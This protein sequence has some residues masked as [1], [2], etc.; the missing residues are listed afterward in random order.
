MKC[1]VIIDPACQEEILIRARTRSELVERLEALATQVPAELI[2]YRESEMAV[3]HPADI[4]CFTVDAHRVLALT[5][6]GEWQVKLRLYALEERLGADFVRINQSCIVNIRQIQRFDSSLGG[7]LRVTLKNGF[8]DY[9]SRRQ[10]RA[11][12]ERMGL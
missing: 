11:A 3:L 12:K 8:R 9:V 7:A 10:L 4:F 6:T 1:T 5:D 2:G